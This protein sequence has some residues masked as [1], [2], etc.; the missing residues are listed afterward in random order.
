MRMA[1]MQTSS[2]ISYLFIIVLIM[3]FALVTCQ[4]ITSPTEKGISSKPNN[5]TIVW[6]VSS[7][8]SS[9][10]P[11]SPSK[12]GRKKKASPPPPPSDDNSKSNGSS[13]QRAALN[14]VL[15][16]LVTFLHFLV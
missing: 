10:T 8:Y 12:G 11:S 13:V 3:V 9:S 4:F 14:K 7:T 16:F 6:Q 2:E 1:G 5:V 15:K